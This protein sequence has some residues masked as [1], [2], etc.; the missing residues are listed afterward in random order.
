MK[1]PAFLAGGLGPNLLGEHVGMTG[2]PGDFGD[3]AQVDEP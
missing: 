2:V 1:R 3:H